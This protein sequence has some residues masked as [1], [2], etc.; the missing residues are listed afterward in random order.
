[1]CVL[2]ANAALTAPTSPVIGTITSPLPL[3]ESASASYAT[4]ELIVSESGKTN[5]YFEM[6][7]IYMYV[8]VFTVCHFLVT[9][10]LAAA[11]VVVVGDVCYCCVVVVVV[12][13]NL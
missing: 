11:V 5:R 3:P 12:I 9:V 1:M 13:I 7:T 2:K 6:I 8:C 10:P 4:A